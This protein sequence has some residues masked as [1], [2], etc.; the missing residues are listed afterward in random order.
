MLIFAIGKKNYNLTWG[1]TEIQ[2]S[3]PLF[4]IP[5]TNSMALTPDRVPTETCYFKEIIYLLLT[6]FSFL[7]ILNFDMLDTEF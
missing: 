5:V 4:P 2:T 3:R 7:L 6:D 1:F